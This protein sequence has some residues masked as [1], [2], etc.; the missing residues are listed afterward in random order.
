MET[1][2][3]TRIDSPAMRRILYVCCLVLLSSGCASASNAPRSTP[4]AGVCGS[5]LV[6]HDRI[7]YAESVVGLPARAE[8]LGV[9]GVPSCPDVLGGETG[10]SRA[11]D[12]IGLAGVSPNL[13][14]AV[15]DDA[16]H[17]YFAAGYFVQ[18]PSHP[19]HF[20]LAAAPPE[21]RGPVSLRLVGRVERNVGSLA[22]RGR[23]VLVDARTRIAGL[24]RGG[25]PY[26]GVGRDVA[27][28]AVR[29]GSSLVARG[30]EPAPERP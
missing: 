9:A 5:D 6:W 28:S 19:L 15:A 2:R 29:C 30:I 1:D 26:V 3:V 16:Q 8:S 21:C 17:G 13:A 22:L 4:I 11:V 24:S 10:A 20:V 25:L 23:V 7:Y 27:V 12:V 18:L 14:L